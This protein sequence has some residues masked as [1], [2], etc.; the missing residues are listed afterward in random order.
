MIRCLSFREESKYRPHQ[1]I[2]SD[3]DNWLP[4][5]AD[6]ARMYDVVEE[7]RLT[8]RN[9]IEQQKAEAIGLEPQGIEIASQAEGDWLIVER[10]LVR[11]VL[12]FLV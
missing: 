3:F 9:G 6:A 5:Q 11:T 1:E 12:G 8:F 7:D 10:G 4:R 2:M